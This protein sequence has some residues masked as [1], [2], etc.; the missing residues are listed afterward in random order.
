MKR[1]ILFTFIVLTI[2]ACK[3]TGIDPE[4]PTDV[5]IYNN[6]AQVF[7]NV[8]VKTSDNPVYTNVEHNFGTINPGTYSQYYRVDIAYPLADVSLT[9]NG[10]QYSVPQVDYTYLQYMSTMKIAYW[11]TIEDPVN[12][13]L[14]I[15]VVAEAEIDD[16]K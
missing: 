2:T 13:I 12:H 14:G 1:V 9:I 15:E 5:R 4:G 7:E 3:K 6:T 11:I 10:V 16:L 8:V